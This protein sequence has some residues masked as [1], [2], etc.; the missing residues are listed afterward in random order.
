MRQEERTLNKGCEAQDFKKITYMDMFLF[1]KLKESI[2]FIRALILYFEGFPYMTKYYL[3]LFLNE[4]YFWTNK[5]EPTKSCGF[6]NLH[7]C[8][9]K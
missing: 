3:K 9:K 4:S 7:G 6:F 8:F 2:S 5:K 1:R